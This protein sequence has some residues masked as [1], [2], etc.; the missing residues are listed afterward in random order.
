MKYRKHP[1]T[2]P[3]AKN[4]IEHY[5]EDLDWY[6]NEYDSDMGFRSSM[7]AQIQQLEIGAIA[8]HGNHEPNVNLKAAG[9]GRQMY[10]VLKLLPNDYYGL[11]RVWYTEIKNRPTKDAIKA[12]HYA[13][14]DCQTIVKCM[15]KNSTLS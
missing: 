12:A 1:N 8:E 9:R 7:S 6:F 11:L 5:S 13:F 15:M 2:Q 4:N 3:R 14:Y 10:H